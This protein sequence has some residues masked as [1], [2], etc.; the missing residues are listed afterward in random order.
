MS[1]LRKK[2]PFTVYYKDHIM[3]LKAALNMVVMI[4]WRE[5]HM[6]KYK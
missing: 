3:F 6:K 5:W 2:G 4:F 1:F